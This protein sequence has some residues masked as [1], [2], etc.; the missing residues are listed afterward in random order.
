MVEVKCIDFNT[1]LTYRVI[2]SEV[3]NE[4]MIKVI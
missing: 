3:F 1:I 4:N 2:R